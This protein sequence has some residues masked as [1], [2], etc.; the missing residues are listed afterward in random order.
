MPPAADCYHGKSDERK[1]E[2]E[3]VEPGLSL[4]HDEDDALP[5][6]LARGY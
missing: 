4:V 1:D 5:A 3:K 6:R 2:E